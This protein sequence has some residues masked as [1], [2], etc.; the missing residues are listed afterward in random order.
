VA[1]DLV[2]FTVQSTDSQNGRITG[3]TTARTWRVQLSGSV[4]NAKSTDG[5]DALPQPTGVGLELIIT[6]VAGEPELQNI[7]YN[8]VDL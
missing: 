4:G 2:L 7:T 5:T 1:G 6:T 3:D 8:G